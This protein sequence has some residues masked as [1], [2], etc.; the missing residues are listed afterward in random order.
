MVLNYVVI[1][2]GLRR[3]YILRDVST[4]ITFSTRSNNG[5]RIILVQNGKLL[6]HL[7]DKVFDA[8]TF[9]WTGFLEYQ[10]HLKDVDQN[11]AESITNVLE[12]MVEIWSQ[13]VYK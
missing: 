9:R 7:I 11:A 13:V 5:C 4:G 6:H 3:A 1:I 10:I 8:W 12:R 2:Q